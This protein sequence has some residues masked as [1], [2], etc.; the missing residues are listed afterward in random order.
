MM[1]G[2]SRV[3]GSAGDAGSAV[4]MSGDSEVYQIAPGDD[5]SVSDHKRH[6]KKT[7]Q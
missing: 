6:H 4:L 5:D 3:E 1:R 7:R 2:I